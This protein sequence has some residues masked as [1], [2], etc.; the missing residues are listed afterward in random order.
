MSTERK[1][2]EESW[3]ADLRLVVVWLARDSEGV[4]RGHLEAIR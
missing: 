1:A 3:R 4:Q 2:G